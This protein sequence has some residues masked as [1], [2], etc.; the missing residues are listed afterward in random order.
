MFYSRSKTFIQLQQY[1]QSYKDQCVIVLTN[2]LIYSIVI[3]FVI[4]KN[5]NVFH[6]FHLGVCVCASL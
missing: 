2:Y 6:E 1:V 3:T 5:L 4:V